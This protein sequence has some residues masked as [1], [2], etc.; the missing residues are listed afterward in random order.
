VARTAFDGKTVYI[1]DALA[2]PE[3]TYGGRNLGGYRTCSGYR[4]YEIKI[5]SASWL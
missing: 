5:V 1:P 3:Y 2:D 4:C